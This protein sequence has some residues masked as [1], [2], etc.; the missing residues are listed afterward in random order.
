MIL[1]R[2]PIQVQQLHK[3]KEGII[4]NFVVSSPYF[5]SGKVYK[6]INGVWIESN[7]NDRSDCLN[8]RT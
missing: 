5:M 8:F 2:V 1:M 6:Q 4:D 7:D 3:N